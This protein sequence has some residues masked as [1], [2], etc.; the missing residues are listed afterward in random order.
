[1]SVTV[2][3]GGQYGSEGKGKVAY[4]LAQEKN[5]EIAVRVGG[6]NSGHTVY[7]SSDEKYIFRHLPT[8][9]L[10]PNVICILPSGSYI[11]IDVL[12]S[13]MQKT[14]I[15][16]D[17]LLID[18]SAMIITDKD[19]EN[20]HIHLTDNIGSTGSGT[21][22]A[23]QRRIN[24]SK[25]VSFAKDEALLSPYIQPTVPFMR[26][27]L[28]QGHRII[29]EGTQ[30]YELSILH[31][32][33]YPYVTSRDTTA[34]GFVSETGL[35]PLDVDEV[36]LTIRAHPIRVGGNSG[37]LP[38]EIDW[39]TVTQ[40]SGSPEHIIEYTSVT[41]KVRRVARFHPD[42]VKK[43]IAVNK[44]S[45]IVLNHLDYIDAKCRIDD[46]PTEKTCDFIREI[47]SQLGISIGYYGF[48]PASLVKKG[49]HKCL[50]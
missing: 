29:I 36:I 30:G 25:D 21:G 44:P 1:M 35:S 3:V 15:T 31:S 18:P 13:E 16:P 6:S 9:S 34:A 42:V 10:L 8:P 7:D 49:V 11:D 43:A 19:R 38:D 46:S 33:H 4:F 41:K 14:G 39:E 48:G 45:S 5:A 22:A 47:E 50:K 24:R 20:E 12:R 17:R 27:K 32:D 28:E 40:E 23:V 2:I 37:P 26:E